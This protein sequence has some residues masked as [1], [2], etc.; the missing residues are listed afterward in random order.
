MFTL[1]DILLTNLT[2][3]SVNW[4]IRQYIYTIQ[5]VIIILVHPKWEIILMLV[6]NCSFFQYSDSYIRLT[7]PCIVIAFN[8]LCFIFGTVECRGSHRFSIRIKGSGLW[9]NRMDL[10]KVKSY[11]AHIAM[12]KHN[13][14]KKF[15]KT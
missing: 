14:W 2:W 12:K 4:M 15:S 8:L 1:S 6:L 10:W 5:S 3:N 11:S 9:S 13:S 7:A